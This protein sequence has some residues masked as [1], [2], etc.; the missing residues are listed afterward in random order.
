VMNRLV[1]SLVLLGTTALL[2]AAAVPLQARTIS[3][4]APPK[5]ADAGSAAVSTAWLPGHMVISVS[6]PVSPSLPTWTRFCGPGRVVVRLRGK[7]Y[8]IRGGYCGGIR[9]G[10]ARWL[11][12][13]LIKNG[14]ASPDAKGFSIVLEPGDRMGRVNIVDSIVQ[15]AGLNLAPGGTAV[16]AEGL[17]SGTFALILAGGKRLTGSWTCG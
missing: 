1:G 14:G 3:G 6:V 5:C 2:F 16:V 10:G 8:A 9:V 12:F 4:V 17:K 15:V 13:G 11:W 7:S